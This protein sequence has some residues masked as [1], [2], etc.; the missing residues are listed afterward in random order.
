MRGDER[1][2]KPEKQTL[3]SVEVKVIYAPCT[4][5]NERMGSKCARDEIDVLSVHP[6]G[7][8]PT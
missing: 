4:R 8:L 6:M 1:A 2:F 3:R 5:K 7:P